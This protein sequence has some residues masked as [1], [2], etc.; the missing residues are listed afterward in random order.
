MSDYEFPTLDVLEIAAEE[1]LRAS[2]ETEPDN[3]EKV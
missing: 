1:S 3:I 2:N